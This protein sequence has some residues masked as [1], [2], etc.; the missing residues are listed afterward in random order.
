MR[1]HFSAQSKTCLVIMTR[2]FLWISRESD[3]HG[4]VWKTSFKTVLKAVQTQSWGTQQT[5]VVRAVDVRAG[6]GALA[7]LRLLHSVL[8]LMKR[9]HRLLASVSVIL[10][11]GIPASIP[12]AH[13]CAWLRTETDLRETQSAS[14][15]FVICS[16]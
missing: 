14:S 11:V 4:L 8:P 12:L 2:H 5:R 13:S 9:G 16:R 15:V 10:N 3:S 1:W 6:P 7:L